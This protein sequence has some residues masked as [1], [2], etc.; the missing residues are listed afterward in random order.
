MQWATGVGL[1]MTAVTGLLLCRLPRNSTTPAY[2][3]LSPIMPLNEH[4]DNKDRNSSSSILAD[5][6]SIENKVGVNTADS[7]ELKPNGVGVNSVKE[8][9]STR[10]QC[11][12]HYKGSNM[13]LTCIAILA[14]DFQVAGVKSYFIIHQ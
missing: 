13:L 14:V 12:S 8:A 7:E 10:V 2:H 6:A 1:Y 9:K 4:G 5:V 3:I 11:L